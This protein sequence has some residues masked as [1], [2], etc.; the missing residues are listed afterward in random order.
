M[1]TLDL[2]GLAAEASTPEEA[3]ARPRLTPRDLPVR[4]AYTSPDGVYHESVVI[5]RILVVDEAAK[6]ARARSILT[7]GRPW[8]TFSP[9]DQAWMTSAA[10]VGI[11][12]RDIPDWLSK[13]GMVDLGLLAQLYE[14]CEGHTSR[15]FRG[16]VGAGEGGSGAPRVSVT[17]EGA[18]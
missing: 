8:H 11:Q 9:E 7:G 3:P 15:Y 4:V 6:V 12:L 2:R 5:S 14:V 1:S 18:P 17:V 10:L 16:D 13:W